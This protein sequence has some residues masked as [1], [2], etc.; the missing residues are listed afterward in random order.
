[1]QQDKRYKQLEDA[2]L[3]ETDQLIEKAKSQGEKMIFELFKSAILKKYK[4]LFDKELSEGIVH[5]E[6]IDDAV[7]Y[8]YTD[9]CISIRQIP[10][11]GETEKEHLIQLGKKAKETVKPI[12]EQLLIKGGINIE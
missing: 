3:K 11:M 4:D 8:C 12:I 2:L 7:E 5:K 6:T 10:K 1:M 9:I